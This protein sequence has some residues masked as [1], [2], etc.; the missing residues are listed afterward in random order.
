MSRSIISIAPG[1]IPDAMIFETARGRVLDIGE[2]REDGAMA[3]GLAHQPQRRRRDDPAGAFRTDHR[4][5]QIVAAS[6]VDRTAERDDFAIGEH[7]LR[8]R[9]RD[10]W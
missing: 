5:D 10:W 7:Q 2:G 9:G 8:A 4:A 6:L 3:F 1:I